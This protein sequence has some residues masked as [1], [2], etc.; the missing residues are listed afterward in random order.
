MSERITSAVL[1]LANAYMRVP[2]GSKWLHKKGGQYEVLGHQLDTDTGLA[3]VRYARFA[4][5]DYDA[6]REDGL[7]YSRPLQEWKA[8]RFTLL[9]QPDVQIAAVT[10]DNLQP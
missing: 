8:D 9:T 6:K 1:T 7:E 3:R 10:L 5:P 2:A 4:G